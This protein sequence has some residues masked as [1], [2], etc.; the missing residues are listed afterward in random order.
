[1]NAP[2]AIV[3]LMFVATTVLGV[4]LCFCIPRAHAEF[5]QAPAQMWCASDA[6]MN[7]F[8]ETN[9]MQKAF[10]ATSGS[11]GQN[12]GELWVNMDTH[13]WLMIQRITDAKLACVVVGGTQYTSTGLAI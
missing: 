3:R 12:L 11:A 2:L 10:E 5:V 8:I 4:T 1:M 7:A 13:L 6:E 9:H